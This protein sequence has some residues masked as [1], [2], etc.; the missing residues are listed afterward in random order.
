VSR[1]EINRQRQRLDDLFAK[2]RLLPDAE[3]Q[4]HWCRYL[5]VLVSGF[6]E[7]AV[8]ISYAELARKRADT[9]VADFVESRL[10]QFVNPR[11]G[12]ILEL[13]G[14]FSQEWKEKLAAATDGQ[15]GESVNSIVGNRHKIAHGESVSLTLSSLTQ[16]YRDAISVIE[17]LRTHCGL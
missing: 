5:C 2:A 3:M 14:G 12:T 11:M 16:Y 8:R 15:L 10:R 4:S 17:L 13:A 9:A 6:V 7:N 1:V